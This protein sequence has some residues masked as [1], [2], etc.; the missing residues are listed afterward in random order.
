[1]EVYRNNNEIHRDGFCTREIGPRGGVKVSTQVWRFSGQPQVW[2]RQPEK[3]RIP[4]KYG[5]YESWEVN[6]DNMGQFHT[7]SDCPLNTATGAYPNNT[8]YEK[9]KANIQESIA[10]TSYQ[11]QHGLTIE[12]LANFYDCIAMLEVFKPVGYADNE[13]LMKWIN[14]L[15]ELKTLL[16]SQVDKV[17]SLSELHAYASVISASL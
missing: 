5:M 11:T 10:I 16:D 1:M 8:E 9:D 13:L 17:N 15:S 3:F 7:D 12:A 4:I 2:K 6:Q 14:R